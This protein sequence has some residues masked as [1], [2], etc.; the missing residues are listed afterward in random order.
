MMS[1]S[2]IIQPFAEAVKALRTPQIQKPEEKVQSRPLKP[3]MDEYIPEK[4]PDLSGLYRMGKDE[5]GHPKIYFDSVERKSGVPESPETASN[6]QTSEQKAFDTENPG[7]DK[8]AKGSEKGGKKEE[9][10][11]A[12]TDKV[13]REIEKLRKKQQELE[14]RIGS[15]TDESKIRNMKSQLNQVERELS[16]KDNDTYRRQH[17]QFS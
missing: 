5:D 10:C 2:G 1:I 14:Q 17:T 8:E 6:L 3:V 4:K 15:E 13:D 7:Q 12:N 11:I 16:Q 9:R